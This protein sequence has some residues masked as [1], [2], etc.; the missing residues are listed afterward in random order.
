M[1]HRIRTTIAALT[2]AALALLAAPLTAAHAA[3]PVAD[4]TGLQTAFAA[5]GTQELALNADIV[6]PTGEYLALGTGDDIILDL[7]GH[8]LSI[9]EDQSLPT[10]RAAIEVPSGAALTITDSAGGGALGVQGGGYAP[11]IGGLQATGVG[12]ITIDGGTITARGGSNAAGIGG[13]Y[14]GGAG[15]IVINGGTVTANGGSNGAGIGGGLNNAATGSVT[16]NG[17]S[18]TATGSSAAA[19]IGGGNGGA[20]GGDGIPTTITGGTVIARGHTYAAGI[21]GGAAGDGTTVVLSGGTVIAEGGARGAGIGAGYNTVGSNNQ[22]PQGTLSL[23]GT[24]RGATPGHGGTAG[25]SKPGR[26]GTVSVTAGPQWFTASTAVGS[27][28]EGRFSIEFGWSV[29]FDANGGTPGPDPAT[30]DVADVEAVPLPEL[31][32]DGYALTSWRVGTEDGPIWAPEA[33]PTE[34]LTLVAHWATVY[35]ITYDLDGGTVEPPNP[36]AYHAE[37]APITLHDPARD[38]FVFLGWTGTDLD[39]PTFDVI[40]PTGSTGDRSYTATWEADTPANLT[41]PAISGDTDLGAVLSAST[42]TWSLGD[43][44]YDYQ[45]FRGDTAI[46]GATDSTHTITVDDL[47]ETLSVEVTAYREGDDRYHPATA[48][49]ADLDIPAGALDPSPVP[50]IA[51]VGPDGAE[52]GVELTAVPGEWGPEGVAL[53]YQ[54]RIDGDDVDG[55][56]GATFTPRPEHLDAEI[57]VAVTGTLDRFT[58][59]TRVSETVTVVPGWMTMD[60]PII[61]GDAVVGAELSA[62]AT[63][64]PAADAFAYEWLRDGDPIDGA[65]GQTYVLTADD[66][67][68]EVSVRVT[69]TLL[70]YHD[71]VGTSDAVTAEPGDFDLLA[72]PVVDGI[73]GVGYEL[74]VDTGAWAPEPSAIVVRWL[75]GDTEL[76]TGTA[77]LLTATDE[78]AELTVEVTATLAGYRD[79]LV[80]LFVT[81]DAEPA[82]VPDAPDASE[83][84]D[85]TRGGVTAT[86]HGS[87]ATLHI[88]ELDGRWVYVY[89]YSTPVGLGWHRVDGGT[90]TVSITALDAGEH[91]LAVLTTDGELA[92]WAPLAA[93]PSLATTG[94]NVALGVLAALLLLAGGLTAIVMGR[95]GVTRVA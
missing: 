30:I 65:T 47:T 74:T 5:G 44:S 93:I 54:W 6:A 52:V 21:G 64:T 91:R 19:G 25:D 56:T 27:N 68:L 31:T 22:L 55:A 63:T 46:D 32:R 83:L 61:I 12:T 18:V 35:T 77:Y 57:G 67:G 16:I 82:G 14:L 50:A 94:A 15:T 71:A 89:G 73:P 4:W 9:G 85:A 86:R 69:A 49:S 78:G 43:L 53:A 17:G 26:G 88:P 90:V 39:E 81:V 38:G 20:S 8:S 75:D 34:D 66:E 84:D 72:S 87:T 3:E 33:T 45:W 76:A 2:A 23:V 59:V 62:S 10:E 79:Y 36:T 1:T 29:T 24:A 42:G 11:G 95:R 40:I 37:Q 28:R 7:N 58:T 13:G 51:G 92:G 41:P 60:T 80:E 70:G 48:R